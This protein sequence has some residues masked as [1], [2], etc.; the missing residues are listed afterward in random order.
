MP[1]DDARVSKLMYASVHGAIQLGY[2]HHLGFII[3]TLCH[4]CEMVATAAG[5][6][7]SKHL[8]VA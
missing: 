2:V 4:Y 1:G 7:I 8:E 6:K 5:N 3:H